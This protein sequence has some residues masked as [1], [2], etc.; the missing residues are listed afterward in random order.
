MHLKLLL[1]VLKAL[2]LLSPHIVN[3]F[4]RCK[5][6]CYVHGSDDAEA[7]SNLLN[8][9]RS[10]FSAQAMIGM[11]DTPQ[12]CQNSTLQGSASSELVNM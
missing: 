5:T 12:K 10:K 7:Y 4:S 2:H 3:P 1:Y 11:R 8:R 9:T 6:G